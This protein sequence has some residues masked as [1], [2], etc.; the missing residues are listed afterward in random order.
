M[1]GFVATICIQSVNQREKDIHVL[2][3]ALSIVTIQTV[4]DNG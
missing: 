4:W 2:K 3:D 1:A